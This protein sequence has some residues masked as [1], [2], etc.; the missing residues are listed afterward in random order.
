MS[1]LLSR[2]LLCRKTF[3]ADKNWI[4]IAFCV[5]LIID[6]NSVKLLNNSNLTEQEA[7][8]VW[9]KFIKLINNALKSRKESID[10]VEKLLIRRKTLVE[11]QSLPSNIAIE[12]TFD[13]VKLSEVYYCD[14]FTVGKKTKN[15]FASLKGLFL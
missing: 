4:R 2:R 10:F 12:E 5:L 15:S 1:I 13:W 3:E 11:Y 9:S 6:F 7:S 8:V 14:S